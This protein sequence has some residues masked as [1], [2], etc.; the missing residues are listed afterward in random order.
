M[1]TRLVRAV[2]VSLMTLVVAFATAGRALTESQGAPAEDPFARLTFRNIG[3]ATMAGRIDDFAVLES[4]PAVFYVATATGGLWKTVNNG[5]TWE[6]LFDDQDVVSIGDVAIAPNDPNVVWVGSGENNNRQSSSWGNGVYQSTDAGHTWTHRGLDDTRQIARIVVDPVDHDV[7]Y[8]AALGHLWGPNKERGVY[9]TTDGGLTWKQVLFVNEDTGA[10][11]LV[12]DPSDNKVLYAATYQRRRATWGFNGGGPGSAI[13]KSGDAGRTWEK[14]TKGIPEG[15]LGRIGLDVYRNDPNVVYARIE[16][17]KDSGVYRSDD[18]GTSWKKMSDTNPRPVYFSQIRIDPTDDHRIYVLGVQLHI[19]DDGGKTFV[20]NAA[21]HADHHAMWIDPANSNHLMTGTD[22]GVGISWDRGKTWDFVDNM[23]LG[24]FYHVGYD[25]ESPYHV[26]GGLQD[27]NSWGGP[28]AVRS[29][30]GI[31]NAEWFVIGGGDGFVAIV[32]PKDPRTLYTESQDG[33]MNR[34]DRESNERK[35]IRPEPAKGEPPLRWNWNTPMIISP[36]SP[37]TV[38]VCANKVFKSTDRGQ[39]WQAV[40]PD[41]TAGVDRE[42]LSLMGVQ[43]KDVKI[44]KHDGVGAYG[45]IVAFAESPKKA[46]VY[47][48]GA[49]DGT[50]QMSRDDG[51]TWTN[52][53]AKFPGLPK[54]AYVTRLTPSAFDEA[55]VYATFDNHR[56]DDYGT[57]VYASSDDGATWTPIASNLPKGQTVKCLT[58]DLKNPNVLYLGTEFGLFVSLDRGAKWTRLKANLPTVP[59]DEI[60]LHPRDNDMLLA[61]HGRSIWI[62]DDL[63]PIQQ[64]A[65]A[66]KADAFLF[67]SKPATEFN[68][69]GDR[70]TEGDRRFWGKN[71]PAG[72]AVTYYLKQAAKD[73]NVTVRD[74]A[75]TVVREFAGDEMKEAGKAG[76]RRMYWDLRHQPVRPPRGLPGGG[77]GGFGDNVLA[78]PF[79][80]PGDYTVTLTVDGRAAGTRT[81]RV[82]GDPV[83][84]ITEADRKT[85]HDTALTLHTMLATANEAAEAVVALGEQF[86]AMQDAVK[87]ADNPPASAKSAIDEFGK[88][89]AGLRRQLGVPAPGQAVAGGGG[90]FGGMQQNVRGQ[91]GQLKNQIAASTSLPTETQVRMMRD[92]RADLQKVVEE[93]N[94]AIATALPALYKTLA[95]NHVHPAPPKPIKAVGS[96]N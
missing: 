7:V 35:V 90:G 74:P 39:S 72:A 17:E 85:W 10:T 25:M 20:T 81:V 96:G 64:A 18:A 73:V 46:G 92:Q 6:V 44:A 76:I 55:T 28:S 1:K 26:Y 68:P 22:G 11:E 79:V 88:R 66:M 4:N 5:T 49:D 63:A 54:N 67:G 80:L 27:N 2:A 14:L 87:K 16:H 56:N 93:A 86:A 21:M 95:D 36:H 37:T 12:M 78:G 71:P 41:L 77:G 42:T 61:T 32:D 15:P 82:N 8:V 51:K 29:R 30:P 84:A 65:E 24:Q 75:G 53:T 57:Y 47:Y 45:T 34:V 9:K 69:A 13:Y 33:R 19:S 48:T 58:E 83:M 31:S 60:T 52:L 50:V 23:D 89:L 59:I 62:L 91:I 70:I 38:F 94:A 3:P 43:A 40:S